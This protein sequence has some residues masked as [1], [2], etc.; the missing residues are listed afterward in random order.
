MNL[1]KREAQEDIMLNIVDTYAKERNYLVEAGVG[2]EKEH[3]G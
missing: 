1:E 3:A 2:I